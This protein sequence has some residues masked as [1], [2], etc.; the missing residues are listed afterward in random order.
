MNQLQSLKV[1]LKDAGEDSLRLREVV[2]YKGRA[3]SPFD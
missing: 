2:T 1:I 3:F